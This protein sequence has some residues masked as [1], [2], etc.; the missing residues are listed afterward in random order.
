M[1]CEKHEPPYSTEN[2]Q[3]TRNAL[4]IVLVVVEKWDNWSWQIY[5]KIHEKTF[6]V[7]LIF[8]SLS[9]KPVFFDEWF[10]IKGSR[11]HAN[12]PYQPIE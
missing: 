9:M 12:F 7:F 6:T 3:N 10:K 2:K 8:N 11:F 1:I 4:F 5:N